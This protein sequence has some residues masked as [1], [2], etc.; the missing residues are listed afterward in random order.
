MPNNRSNLEPY[1]KLLR[2]IPTFENQSV[3]SDRN[4][5]YLLNVKFT[6]TDGK[7]LQDILRLSLKYGMAPSG[8]LVNRLSE[9]ERQD[10]DKCGI[11]YITLEG[12]ISIQT[13][14]EWVKRQPI[15]G[16][17]KRPH[18][19]QEKLAVDIS[20]TTLVSPNALAILDCLFR[21]DDETLNMFTAY[22]LSSKI[23]LSQPKFSSIMSSL[24]VKSLYDLKSKIA[25]LEPS[26]FA[27]KFRYSRTR[28]SMTPYFKLKKYYHPVNSDIDSIWPKIIEEIQEGPG[29][30]N[31]APSEQ[32]KKMGYLRDNTYSLWVDSKELKS[33]K[34]RYRL[35]PS[36]KHNDGAIAICSPAKDF[37]KEAIITKL[38]EPSSRYQELFGSLN[39]FRVIWDLGF[40]DSRHQELQVDLLWKVLHGSRL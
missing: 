36:Q 33:F 2:S 24:G 31:Y 16:F 5:L 14:F 1:T 8:V 27:K 10:L 22:K 19:N 37:L 18:S 12:H 11:S 28:Q 7:D 29:K 32:L 13:R 9:A 39:I 40:G 4:S 21:L 26:E 17:K 3:K 25:T 35:I 38:D 15:D 34:K 6:L 20:P 30:I 23:G